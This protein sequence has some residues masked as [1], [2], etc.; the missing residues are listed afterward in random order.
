MTY[1]IVQGGGI[2]QRKLAEE[3]VRFAIQ[4]LFPR[5]KNYEIF[6]QLTKD[7]TDVFEEDERTYQVRV[8]TRQNKEDFITGIFHEFVHIDQYLRGRMHDYGYT[9][10]QEYINHPAEVEAYARQEELLKK[11]NT[12]RSSAG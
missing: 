10:F 5:F 7:K 4:Q 2:R 6:I 8:S 9:N 1:Y 12:A 3:A 11:W